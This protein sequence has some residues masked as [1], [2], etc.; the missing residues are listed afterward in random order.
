MKKR[1]F[2]KGDGSVVV[3]SCVEGN[4]RRGETDDQ[5][6]TRIASKIPSLQGLPS[7]DVEEEKLPPK[8][9]NRHK[10]RVSVVGGKQEVAV[11]ALVQTEKTPDQVKWDSV[12]E[13]ASPVEMVLAQRLG[14]EKKIAHK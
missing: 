5:H 3:M 9:E 6:F 8:D 14:L 2:V 13:T 11:D 1:V 7:F 4:R 10:W 12:K